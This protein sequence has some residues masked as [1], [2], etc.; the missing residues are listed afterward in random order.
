M[1]ELLPLLATVAVFAVLIAGLARLATLAR[2][3]RTGGSALG[4]VDE[5]FHPAAYQPRID[6]QLQSER[7]TPLPSAGD[8]PS[9]DGLPTAD[10]PAARPEPGIEGRLD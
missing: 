10:H 4:A 3:R 5:I 2:R 7:K 9:L 6:I 1:G 8:L